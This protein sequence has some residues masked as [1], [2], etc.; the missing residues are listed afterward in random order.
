MESRD[1]HR[2]HRRHRSHTLLTRAA[3]YE[4]RCYI[5]GTPPGASGESLVP[6]VAAPGGARQNPN[7]NPS[8]K[9]NPN[10]NPNPSRAWWCGPLNERNPN[11]NPK[12]EPEPEPEPN[13]NRHPDPDPNPN[14]IP[15]P[16]PRHASPGSRPMHH[17]KRSVHSGF[18]RSDPV[19]FVRS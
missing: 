11:P 16:N 9:S 15:H 12:P 8:P 18:L 19:R 7:P 10:P 14:P 4:Y 5:Y 17:T 3:E 1:S 6:T 13:P 2:S